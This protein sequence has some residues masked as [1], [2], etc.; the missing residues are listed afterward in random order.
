VSR[1]CRLSEFH[2]LAPVVSLVLS[3]APFICP[4]LAQPAKRAIRCLW[5]HSEQA[6]FAGFRHFRTEGVGGTFG[7]GT[8]FEWALASE[9]SLD[10]NYVTRSLS[11]E[12]DCISYLGLLTAV[13]A[14]NRA[15]VIKEALNCLQSSHYSKSLG[16]SSSHH[17]IHTNMTVRCE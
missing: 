10:D 13:L 15:K 12:N 11:A 9:S 16:N 1:S 3:P 8:K 2:G 17:S 4:L 14:L 7:Q 6:N 5:T